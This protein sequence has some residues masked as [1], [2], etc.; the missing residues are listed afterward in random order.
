MS[1]P[2]PLCT[3]VKPS[4]ITC[5]SPAVKGT[6]LCYH[7]SAIRTALGKATLRGACPA[8]PFVFPEDRSSIQINYFLLL[9]AFTEQRI[10]L[11]T[12]NCMQRLL[13]AMAANLG[14][15]PLSQDAA[16][17]ANKAVESGSSKMRACPERSE[18]SPLACDTNDDA[19]S[20][21]PAG[22]SQPAAHS[23]SRA[24]AVTASLR[25]SAKVVNVPSTRAAPSRE[26]ACPEL[27]K[28]A[29][30]PEEIEARLA[31]LGPQYFARDGVF[32]AAL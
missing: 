17:T 28:G 23:A 22:R 6:D 16:T 15:I 21:P 20:H 32:A 31:D 19:S 8:I 7:H 2:A 25:A 26:R 3:H 13:R 29:F 10:D 12:F 11:R 4:G 5:G 30:T 24:L 1:S 9:Q 14:K 27:V 18:R